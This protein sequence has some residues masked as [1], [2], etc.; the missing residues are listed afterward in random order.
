MDHERHRVG[1]RLVA[2]RVRRPARQR[3]HVPRADHGPPDHPVGATD[4]ERE[5]AVEHVVDLAGGVAVH[6]R[7][8]AT[9]RHPHQGREQRTA[10]VRAVREHHHLVGAQGQTRRLVQRDREFDR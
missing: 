4:V 8:A 6:D 9:R 1:V 2:D 5:L 3:H 7:R 10:G